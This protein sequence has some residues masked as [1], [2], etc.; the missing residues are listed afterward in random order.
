MSVTV[1]V[2]VAFFFFF[3]RKRSKRWGFQMIR[4][5]FHYQ[6]RCLE[7]EDR[8]G[9]P[10]CCLHGCIGMAA[11]KQDHQEDTLLESISL[12]EIATGSY[13]FFG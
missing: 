10:L 13:V 2:V 7:T 5:Q 11:A 9:V 12:R 6:G 8:L 1:F 3:L 4:F